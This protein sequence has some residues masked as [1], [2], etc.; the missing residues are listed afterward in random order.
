MKI[1]NDWEAYSNLRHYRDQMEQ[2]KHELNRRIRRLIK[3]LRI[4]KEA[5]EFY[6]FKA[7]HNPEAKSKAEQ[8][9]NDEGIYDHG[10]KA[11]EARAKIEEILNGTT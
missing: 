3:A 8:Y 11:R 5:L 4:S 9:W 7:I 10:Q 1:L 6:G 2:D